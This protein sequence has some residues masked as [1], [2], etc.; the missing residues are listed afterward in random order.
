M[1]AG[2]CLSLGVAGL[3]LLLA[4][5][6]GG[7]V[8]T[9][10]PNAPVILITIDTLR[11]DRLP[12]Y[13]FAGVATPRFDQLR[14]DGI[15]F[16][17]AYSHYP[18]TLPSHASILTG[19]L[20][21]EHGVRDNVGYQLDTRAHPYLPRLLQERGYTTGA[22]VSAFVLAGA[23]SGLA[24]HFDRYD[25]AIESGTA[26]SLGGVQRSGTETSVA[27]LE[28]LTSA[29]A[30]GKPIFLFLHLYEPHTPYEPPEPFRTRY[31]DRYLGEVAA[32]DDVLGK[33]LD[34][35]DRRGL[36]ESALIAVL[37]DHGEGLGDHGE[38]EHGILLYREA[39]Q[40]PLLLKLPGGERAGDTVTRP[41][42]LVDVLPTV[43]EQIGAPVPPNLSGRSLLVAEG[44]SPRALYAET[45]YPRIHYG[46][47]EL[48]S[49]VEGDFHLISGPDPE[50][51]HL[52]RDPAERT[53]LRDDDRR[54]FTRLRDSVREQVR[55]LAAPAAADPETSA[56]LAALGYLSSGAGAAAT[57]ELP[58]PKGKVGLLA[59]IGRARHLLEEHLVDESIALLQG[60]VAGNPGMQ[61]AWTTLALALTERGRLSDA[62]GAYQKAIEL[63]GPQPSLVLGA[64]SLLFRLG[65]LEEA[66]DH[67]EL[68]LGGS[69]VQARLQL[70]EI[71][72]GRRD[73]A[74]A[75][76]HLRAAVAVRATA[77]V[78]LLELAKVLAQR[79]QIEEAKRTLAMAETELARRTSQDP[80]PN[81]HFL[82]GDLA[83]RDGRA[84]AAA[85]ELQE[86]IRLY[87]KNFEAYASL[88]F[89]Y[90]FQ[91]R[92]D[93]SA[94]VLAK[95]VEEVPT[96][97]AYAA[98]VDTLRALGDPRQAA[99]LLVYAR[100]RFPG[101]E[102]LARL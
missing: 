32:A 98:A 55:E 48:H 65:R 71:A 85:A 36:Y 10:H 11:S 7:D 94:A 50:L 68:A 60:F 57:G 17:R 2:R 8:A 52:E 82:R 59:E 74:A 24:S 51:Y 39:L 46:W 67:A 69:A 83:L 101:S 86:E 27:A 79:N 91:G 77:T 15:L 37:S 33:F 49:L 23:H 5:C 64:S 78:P 89:A 56:R 22:A 19:L 12:A 4:G 34:E 53:N 35:L 61:D 97:A 88:A 45:Y 6:P 16:E 26:N 54:T 43:L 9:V 70:A 90:A 31:A 99:A 63:A 72:R 84:E 3:A 87:P 13:G 81:L 28:W 93:E 95:M 92:G 20:P 1:F 73:L 62:L 96:P 41:V 47:S 76:G 30:S 58:D 40:V 42:Q 29:Q 102:S 66:E 100:G 18:L 44:G 14:R 25:D 80:L 21:T 75:E 38:A